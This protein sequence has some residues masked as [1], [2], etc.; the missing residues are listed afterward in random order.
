MK[1]MESGIRWVEVIFDK[2]GVESN[3]NNNIH[4][5]RRHHHRN[6]KKFDIR[7][8]IGVYVCVCVFVCK[9]NPNSEVSFCI[10]CEYTHISY[11]NGKRETK[12][13]AYISH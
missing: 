9:S 7:K 10:S 8:Q 4:H 5:H 1:R 6:K 12:L 2:N 13:F 11:L 3:K